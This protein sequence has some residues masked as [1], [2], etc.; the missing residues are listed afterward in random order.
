MT[1]FT[2]EEFEKCSR[3]NGVRFWEAHDFMRRL[4]YESWTAFQGVINKAMGSCIKLNIDPTEVFILNTII[5]EEKEL[6][7]YKLT[8]FGCF[9]VSMHADS[10]K[11]EVMK[12]R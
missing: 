12:I 6:K 11:P 5:N 7:T 2:V 8:R 4:G 1:E 9:L 10:K 3:Q